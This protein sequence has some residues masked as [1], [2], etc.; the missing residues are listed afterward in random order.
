MTVSEDFQAF[1]GALAIPVTTRTSIASRAGLITRRLN[2]EYRNL[3]SQDIYSLYVGSF[4]RG[5]AT[6]VTSDVDM[7][8]WLPYEN[9]VRFNNHLGNGQSA[10]LQE[11]RNALQKTYPTTQIG[12]DGQ[13]V[14]IK[15]T[16]GRTFE[17]LPAFRNTDDS[18]T[19]PDTN[20]GGSWKKANP[21]PEIAAVNDRDKDCNGNL[22]KLC[23]MARAWKEKWD[24][25][26]SGLLLDTLAYYFIKNY[27]YRNMSYPFFDFMSRDF[28]DYLKQQDEERSYW[29]SPGANQYVWRTGKFEYKA[30]RCKNIAM[31]ACTYQGDSYGWAARQ[32]WREIYGTKYPG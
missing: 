4:G 8:V 16:D 22:K 28:F 23:R 5:T 26:I 19:Y 27:E 29:L 11:V 12:A 32:K 20:N 6:A 3:D 18:F 9:Y 2:L 21:R 25:P 31:E 13:V 14:F 10:M 30:L 1:C 24:V 15:F 7:I 17:I